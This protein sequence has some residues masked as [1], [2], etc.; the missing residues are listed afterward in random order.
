MSAF[1]SRAV[2]H[3]AAP[4]SPRLRQLAFMYEGYR[5]TALSIELASTAEP[6]RYQAGFTLEGNAGDSM[7]GLPAGHR[8]FESHIKAL[9]W[10]RLEAKRFI[11]MIGKAD[12]AN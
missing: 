7:P 6:K 5:V 4:R 11:V 1:D 9:R 10:A 8:V 3:F 12:R 2:P